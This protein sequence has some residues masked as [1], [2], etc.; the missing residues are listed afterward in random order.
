MTASINNPG[1]TQRDQLE[2]ALT[3]GAAIQLAAD[4]SK[5]QIIAEGIKN[6][7]DALHPQPVLYSP[8]TGAARDDLRDV[9][10]ATWPAIRSPSCA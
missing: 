1:P 10:C 4:P 6:F 8:H 3:Q 9:T 5:A 7:L 2:Y